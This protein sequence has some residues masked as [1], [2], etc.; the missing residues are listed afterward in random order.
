MRAHKDNV[1]HS[2]AI[3]RGDRLRAVG[4]AVVGDHHLARAAATGEEARALE[5]R[6]PKV[7]ASLKHGINI[8]N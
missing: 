7:P 5:M 4:A 8:S 6:L 1:N 3:C 2:G